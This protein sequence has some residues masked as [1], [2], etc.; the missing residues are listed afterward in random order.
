MITTDNVLNMV[1]RNASANVD[2]YL[3]LINSRII[4]WLYVNT[5]MIA[6]K[7][8][9]PQVFISAL[10]ELPIPEYKDS[11]KDKMVWLVQQIKEKKVKLKKAK[12]EKDTDN[13][14]R[15]IAAIDSEIDH[16]VYE[17]YDLTSEEIK[18][19]EGQS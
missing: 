17:L 10:A 16:L 12:S 7:D 6:Q 19:I 1:P 9:F 18:I 11:E 3:G 13:L 14:S 15:E 4:S 2:F 5:S 8:D